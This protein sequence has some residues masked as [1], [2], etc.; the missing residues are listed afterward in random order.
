[1]NC[2]DSLPTTV[3][4]FVTRA[5]A[6]DPGAVYDWSSPAAH[7]DAVVLNLGT[8]DSGH[9][10]GQAWVDAFQDTYVAFLR[11]LT[12][13]LGNS[14]IPIFA[15]V[16]PITNRYKPWVVNAT[17]TAAALFGVKATV[18]DYTGCQLDGCGHPGVA[19]HQCM[20]A[21][22]QPVV[23]ATMGWT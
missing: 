10:N 11:N 20:F 5:L 6:Q 22:A 23:A 2:C 3:P 12:T 18:V 19:G 14:S 13:W 1:M 21:I 15:G 9:D 17:A 8:N 7:A 4:V 16:G